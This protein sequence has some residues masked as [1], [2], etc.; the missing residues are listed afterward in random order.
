MRNLLKIML[1]GAYGNFKKIFFAHDR[2]TD[3]ELRNNILNGNIKPT[4][5][6]SKDSCIGCGG[7]A[8]VCP[9]K[10]IK[11][12]KLEKQEQLAEGW[13]KTE[14]PE[15]NSEKCV[16]C[17][18]CHDFCP[19]YALFGEK[20]TIHPNDVG[21]VDFDLDG[22]INK[23]VKIS[24]DKLAFISQFL[25]DK[26][27]IKNYPVGS[28]VGSGINNES[29]NVDINNESVNVDINDKGEE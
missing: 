19:I 22:M 24:E 13:I 17:Y 1:E 16:F 26:T 18:Y 4:D 3:I 8:N 25:A 11:M 7:C 12:K 2:V 29:V 15:L 27:V 20:S 6:V 23:P 5:K 21:K 14:I 10:A 9:T 28:G